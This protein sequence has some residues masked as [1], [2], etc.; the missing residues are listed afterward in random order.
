MK[1]CS[2]CH[3]DVPVVRSGHPKYEADGTQHCFNCDQG[4]MRELENNHNNVPGAQSFADNIRFYWAHPSVMSK[5]MNDYP[6]YETKSELAVV[7]GEGQ[8]PRKPEDPRPNLKVVGWK[9]IVAVVLDHGI[10]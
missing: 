2:I 9:K 4:V 1:T 10:D 6:G 7:Q 8:D 5:M 3:D